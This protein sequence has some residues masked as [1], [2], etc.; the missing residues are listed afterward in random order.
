VAEKELNV[1]L[2]RRITVRTQPELRNAQPSYTVHL[3]LLV[4]LIT[5]SVQIMRD[6][7]DTSGRA[8]TTTHL[9]TWMPVFLGNIV[10]VEVLN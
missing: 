7:V 3:E 4:L 6:V 9:P 8:E 10:E 1:L 5:P 2:L